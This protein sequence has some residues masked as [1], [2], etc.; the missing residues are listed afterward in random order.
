MCDNTGVNAR[1]TRVQPRIERK[2]VTTMTD[3]PALKVL[4]AAA[5]T[6]FSPDTIRKAIKNH[7]LPA[8]QM[9]ARGD[10]FI[11]RVD[12]DQ[13]MANGAPTA[14]APPQEPTE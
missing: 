3:A 8:R 7:R 10:W 11:S 1:W 2:N 5:H 9:G 6:G 12:L 4:Q 13:W 14:P